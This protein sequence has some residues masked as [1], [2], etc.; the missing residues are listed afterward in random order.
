MF[1]TPAANGMADASPRRPRPSAAPPRLNTMWTAIPTVTPASTALQRTVLIGRGRTLVASFIFGSP[2]R[3]KHSISHAA[4]M[5]CPQSDAQCR[6]RRSG[7]KPASA[8]S[9][10]SAGWR[11]TGRHIR[12]LLF[13]ERNLSLAGEG[14][15]VH[16]LGLYELAELLWRHGHRID[17]LA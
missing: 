5:D 15:P 3:E 13:V 16:E 9:A 14:G 7:R 8:P 11:Q 17:R 6:P 4:G 12:P 1:Q 10:A 2:I